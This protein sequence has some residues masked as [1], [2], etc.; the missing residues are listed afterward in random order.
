MAEAVFY[1]NMGVLQRNQVVEYQYGFL[2]IRIS[3]LFCNFLV[4]AVVK[5]IYSDDMSTESQGMKKSV[6]Y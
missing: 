3:I 1:I 6:I 4:I 5:I 2:P